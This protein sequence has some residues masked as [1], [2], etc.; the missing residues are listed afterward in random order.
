[1][2]GV[3]SGTCFGG[4]RRPPLQR[5]PALHVPYT[6][7]FWKGFA[8]LLLE[9]LRLFV[10]SWFLSKCWPFFKNFIFAPAPGACAWATCS[11]QLAGASRPT[12]QQAQVPHQSGLQSCHLLRSDAIYL[13]DR[14]HLRHLRLRTSW[15]EGPG[16]PGTQGTRKIV[17]RL[18]PSYTV[19][20]HASSQPRKTCSP[21]P[22]PELPGVLARGSF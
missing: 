9:S 18:K 4:R 15:Q 12:S 11:R 21:V 19:R 3:A 8:D 20:W 5:R 16:R 13:H 22:I 2:E 1:M 17:G 6:C 14:R 7:C 10:D